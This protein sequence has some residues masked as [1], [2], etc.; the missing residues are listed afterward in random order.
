MSGDPAIY[1]TFAVHCGTCEYSACSAVVR[2]EDPEPLLAANFRR[3]P[4]DE[5][6]KPRLGQSSWGFGRGAA[7]PQW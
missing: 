3:T 6:R 1:P 4:G 7:R 2:G 5:R